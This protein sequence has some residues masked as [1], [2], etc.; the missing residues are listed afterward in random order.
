MTYV[1]PNEAAATLAR[2]ELQNQELLERRRARRDTVRE[3]R[4][5][6]ALLQPQLDAAIKDGNEVEA[7]KIA[8]ELNQIDR[9]ISELE[10][11]PIP[12]TVSA[13]HFR[14]ILAKHPRKW[15]RVKTKPTLTEGETPGAALKRLD[16]AIDA[17]IA[18]RKAV[19]RTALAGNEILQRARAQLT[20]LRDLGAPKINA[21]GE[22]TFATVAH[23]L[24]NGAGTIPQIPN[25]VALIAWL[26]PDVLD[27]KIA[28][29]LE[30]EGEGITSDERAAKLK[31]IDARLL[32]LHRQR[33]AIVESDR[34][35][36]HRGDSPVEAALQISAA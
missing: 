27:D 24:R 32:D 33:A 34:T 29:I 14:N 23:G 1:L 11:D 22:L 18:E 4:Q 25:A 9:S 17:A 20:A 15:K 5:R 30:F 35:L 16:A 3:L 28:E 31:D 7:Q 2:L 6:G 10:A 12:S 19:L 8:A 21:R 13:A 26:I 36:F